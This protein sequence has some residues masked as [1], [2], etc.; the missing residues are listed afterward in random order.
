MAK[1]GNASSVWIWLREARELAVVAFGRSEILAKKRLV[2][3]LAAGKLPWDCDDED[4]KA[5]DAAEVAELNRSLAN[6][7]FDSR[8]TVYHKGD[9]RVFAIEG[10]GIDWENSAIREPTY[11]WQGVEADGI[12]V[13]RTHLLE[14]LPATSRANKNAGRQMRRVLPLVKKY[15]PPDGKAPDSVLTK[16]VQARVNAELALDSK[17]QGLGDA[18]WDTVNRALGRDK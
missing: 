1:A 4:W 10:L 5:A 17:N 3:W 15:Y 13:S 9:P 11:E 8:H 12:K 2:G 14:L 16:A 7:G 18:S 6:A